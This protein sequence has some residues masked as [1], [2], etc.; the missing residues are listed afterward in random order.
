MSNILR[1]TVILLT[2]FGGGL[3]A[4]AQSYQPDPRFSPLLTKRSRAEVSALIV[5]PDGRILLNGSHNFLN[6]VPVQGL[7]RLHPDGSLDTT[8]QEPEAATNVRFVA[9]RS[10]GKIAAATFADYWPREPKMTLHLL[11]PDGNAE[12]TYPTDLHGYTGSGNLFIVL[13]DHKILV[14]LNSYA[15]GAYATYIN[16]LNPD[17]TTDPTFSTE[18]QQMGYIRDMVVQSDGKILIA[19]ELQPSGVPVRLQMVRLNADGSYDDSFPWI[20]GDQLFALALQPDGKILAGRNGYTTGTGIRRLNGDG[21]PDNS[22]VAAPLPNG[23][24]YSVFSIALQ[25]DG[26]IVAGSHW[27]DPAEKDPFGHGQVIRLH[28]NGSYDAGFESGTGAEYIV[29]VLALQ[30][31]GNILGGGSFATYSGQAKAGIFCLNG[32]NGNL[33]N[34]FKAKLEGEGFITELI[35]QGDGKILASGG[36]HVAGGQQFAGI[37]RLLAD[38]TVDPG[39]QAVAAPASVHALNA[40]PVWAVAVQADHK[41]LVGGRFSSPDSYEVR[42]L[43]RLNADASPDASFSPQTPQG[44]FLSAVAVQADE[45]ILV[46]LNGSP[47]G[48]LRLFRLNAD[49]TTDNSFQIPA[50]LASHVSKILVQADGKVL[51]SGTF[52]V[53]NTDQKL[54]RFNPDGTLDQTFQPVAA[55]HLINHVKLQPNGRILIAGGFSGIGTTPVL[56]LARLQT[57]GTLDDSFRTPLAANDFIRNLHVQ[58]D[59][60]ILLTGSFPSLN[61]KVLRLNADGTLDDSFSTPGFDSYPYFDAVLGEGDKIV[62]AAQGKVFQITAPLEQTITFAPL[63]GKLTTDSSF[64]LSASASSGLPVTFAVVSGP[65]TVAGNTVTLTGEPGTVTIRATQAGDGAYKPALAVEQSF[66]V[67]PAPT[68]NPGPD[69]MQVRTFP[70]PAPGLFMVKLAGDL[71]VDGMGLFDA[72]GK[73]VAATFVLMPFGYKV[74]APYTQPGLYVL[75]LQT[76]KGRISKRI[77]FR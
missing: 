68:P 50:G 4:W 33:D 55:N 1:A 52:T 7:T 46:G 31:N 21:T 29:P 66:G 75:E 49:G 13:P 25:P 51:A 8:F 28:A 76:S 77:A 36:F 70:N 9:R 61:R 37:T 57:E 65:A 67:Q 74:L 10:D 32:S 43:K 11:G 58:A 60:K 18:S 54:L 41:I 5:Q 42:M 64:V 15:N 44:E 63:P 20:T 17:G 27:S 6:N 22:F 30:Q 26:K 62:L 2:I 53:N 47:S 39:F 45:K 34:S 3:R 56:R 12:A 59:G 72:M 48:A 71:R 24:S 35:R 69:P 40:D 19:G 38:G 16:R 14:A 23:F 73:P